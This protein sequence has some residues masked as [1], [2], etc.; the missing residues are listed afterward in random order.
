M[1]YNIPGEADMRKIRMAALF[2]A[3][4]TSVNLIL[5]SFSADESVTAELMN[6]AKN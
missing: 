2:L 3:A 6:E 1:K 5:P 4:I